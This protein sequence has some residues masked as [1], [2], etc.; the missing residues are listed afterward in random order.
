MEDGTDLADFDGRLG[1]RFVV[2]KVRRDVYVAS[3]LPLLKRRRRIA[4]ACRVTQQFSAVAAFALAQ[5]ALIL[6][7]TTHCCVRRHDTHRGVMFRQ[8]EK[9]VV[10]ELTCPPRVLAIQAQNGFRQ[11]R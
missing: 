6:H 3:A 4:L 11:S 2:E 10:V 5:E 9:I 8:H 7:V 1:S